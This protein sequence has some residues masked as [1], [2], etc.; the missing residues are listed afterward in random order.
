MSNQDQ[1]DESILWEDG[2]SKGSPGSFIDRYL[3][4][5]RA[6]GAAE[7][8]VQHDPFILMP[9]IYLALSFKASRK[10]LVSMTMS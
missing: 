8:Y 4:P 7:G 9:S 6:C 1:L 3:E 2:N 10:F 5:T